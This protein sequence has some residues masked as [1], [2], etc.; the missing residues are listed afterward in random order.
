MNSLESVLKRLKSVT[1][2]A[3]HYD[4]CSS[5]SMHFAWVLKENELLKE[6]ALQMRLEINKAKQQI[7]D[8]WVTIGVGD[9]TG[10]LFLHGP[11]DAIK[12]CQRK[13][14]S[15]KEQL[16]NQAIERARLA[17]LLDEMVD[18]AVS[19]GQSDA[20]K[21][22]GAFTQVEAITMSTMRRLISQK[23]AQIIGYFE[24]LISKEKQP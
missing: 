9:G 4:L 14:L 18:C 2:T 13:L 15:R 16:A 3:P 20:I 19:V 6:Q 7:P 24:E 17:Q 12:E 21:S 1:S 22:V 8:G 11:H 23:R 5:A 10:Q